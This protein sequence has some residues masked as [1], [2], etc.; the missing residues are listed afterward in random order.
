MVNFSKGEYV[1]DPF[2][3]FE[4]TGFPPKILRDVRYLLRRRS[5]C[6]TLYCYEML[7]HF[8]NQHIEFFEA[9]KWIVEASCIAS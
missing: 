2:I 9:A 5:T 1:P 7:I 8:H 3:T 4:A 6:R